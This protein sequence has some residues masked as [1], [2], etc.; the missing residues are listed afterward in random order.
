MG[1][2]ALGVVQRRRLVD[3]PAEPGEQSAAGGGQTV[4]FGVNYFCRST[5]IILAGV[6]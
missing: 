5:T 4:V 1:G 3:E 2:E 6:R